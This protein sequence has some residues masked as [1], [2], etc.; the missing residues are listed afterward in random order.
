M[1]N[2]RPD[3]LQ[4]IQSSSYM[5]YTEY[6]NMEKQVW[7]IIHDGEIRDD[8]YTQED[9]AT[10]MAGEGDRVIPYTIAVQN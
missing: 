8:I 4:R 10:F 9:A 5:P 2:L 1:F 6:M 7:L 3:S